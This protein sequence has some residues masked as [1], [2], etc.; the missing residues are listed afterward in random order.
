[1]VLLRIKGTRKIIIQ[2]NAPGKQ[3]L[4]EVPCSWPPR[5]WLHVICVILWN[6]EQVSDP[7]KPCLLYFLCVAVSCQQRTIY[8]NNSLYIPVRKTYGSPCFCAFLIHLFDEL[9]LSLIPCHSSGMKW[10]ILLPFAMVELFLC[11]S[12]S[13]LQGH[14]LSFRKL[15]FLHW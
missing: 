10:L 13:K 6:A 7:T 12:R 14:R 15:C 3:K 1:M 4:K 9:L 5:N 8:V 11:L 2:S